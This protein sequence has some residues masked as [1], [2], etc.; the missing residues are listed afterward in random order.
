MVRVVIHRLRI[1]KPIFDA[2]KSHI[3]HKL[4]AAGLSQHRT[5]GAILLL[6]LCFVVIN[7]SVYEFMGKNFNA[8]LSTD[9][10]LFTVFNMALTRY[11]HAQTA[12]K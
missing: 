7:L 5:L 3:H 4:M 8:L 6:E 10:L 12:R 9:I 1:G 2:D 11:I